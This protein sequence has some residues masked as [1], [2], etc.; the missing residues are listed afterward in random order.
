MTDGR[1]VDYYSR[2]DLLE[3]DA[4]FVRIGSDLTATAWRRG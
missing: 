2:E 4:S 3:K 1:A